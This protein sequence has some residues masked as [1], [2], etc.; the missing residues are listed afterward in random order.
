[1]RLKWR[2]NWPLDAMIVGES[3]RRRGVT[4][5]RILV[6]EDELIVARDLRTLLQRLGHV[7]I[8]EAANGP[9]A[10]RL[11]AERKPD[12]ILMDIRLNGPMDGIQTACEILRGQ[13]VPI[14]Y[15]TANTDAFLEGRSAMAPPYL[16]VAKPFSE[17]LVHAAIES[18]N[19]APPAIRRTPSA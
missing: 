14:I 9:D 3:E 12:L 6:I 2:C 18:T 5:K 19:F 13:N 8:G 4:A 11:A 10:I 17:T 1:M 16:C 15:V 7:P